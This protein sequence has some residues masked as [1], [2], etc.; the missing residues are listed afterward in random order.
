METVAIQKL[1][2]TY[3]GGKEA[4]KQLSNCLPESLARLEVYVKSWVSIQIS[5]QKKCISFLEL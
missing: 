3:P 1:S 2:K 4:L 5:N